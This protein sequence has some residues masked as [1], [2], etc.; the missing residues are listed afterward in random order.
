MPCSL[1]HMHAG[2]SP[3][4]SATCT[5]IA[6]GYT[7]AKNQELTVSAGVLPLHASLPCSVVA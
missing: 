4:A 3:P 6:I 2:P 1:V 5:V 7:E